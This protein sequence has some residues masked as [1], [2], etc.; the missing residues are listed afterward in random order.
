MAKERIANTSNCV[1]A[2]T[3]IIRAN[4]LSIPTVRKDTDVLG[5]PNDVQ[6]EMG[7]E[8]VGRIVVHVLDDADGTVRLVL[9][10]ILE[11]ER[12]RGVGRI[13]EV[14]GKEDNEVNVEEVKAF[15]RPNVEN[16]V[17]VK[18]TNFSIPI[19]VLV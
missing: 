1:Q 13:R 3:V 14:E 6:K 17:K 5:S 11:E 7:I 10:G 15:V 12:N 18:E 4:G 19:L 9:D 8:N 16:G 2:R